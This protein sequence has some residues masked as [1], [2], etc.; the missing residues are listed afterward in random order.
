MTGLCI[1]LK[2]GMLDLQVTHKSMFFF[3]FVMTVSAACT[4]ADRVTPSDG[5]NP[6]VRPDTGVASCASDAGPGSGGLLWQSDSP[7]VSSAPQDA[8][9][10]SLSTASDCAALAPHPVPAELSWTTPTGFFC[11]GEATVDGEGDL[12]G[13]ICS[14]TSGGLIRRFFDS[15]GDG[16]T[17]RNGSEAQLWVSPETSGFWLYSAGPSACS[18]LRQVGPSGQT[19]S[20]GPSA[21]AG[22]TPNPAGGFIESRGTA[23]PNASPPFQDFEVRWLDDSLSP[24]G[25]WHTALSWTGLPGPDLQ[26]SIFVDRLGRALVLSFAHPKSFGPPAPPSDWRFAAR[27]MDKDG[28]VSPV[29]EPIAPKFIVN[30]AVTWFADWGTLLPLATGGFLAFHDVAGPTG[31]GSTAPSGWYASYGSGLS[32]ADSA[33]DWVRQFDGSIQMLRGGVGYAATHRDASSCARTALLISPSGI[34]CFSAA[35]KGSESCELS[36]RISPDGTLVL[37]DSNELRW[38]PGLARVGP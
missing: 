37:Q 34:A 14:S 20:S 24:Q 5:G 30:G 10:L 27:W 6:D 3:L 23:D 35:L 32:R 28:A 19:L 38:W 9:W 4:R 31:G 21:R 26:L 8:G 22:L 29:F 36:D 7:A 15:T 1:A 13:P 17:V 11:D 16:G 25:D 2:T 12:A 33:P 18:F